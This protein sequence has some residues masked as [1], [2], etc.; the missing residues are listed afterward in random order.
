MQHLLYKV[1]FSSCYRCLV[2]LGF[3]LPACSLVYCSWIG[4][5]VPRCGKNRTA[6]SITL[7][8]EHTYIKSLS[9]HCSRKWAARILS[10]QTCKLLLEWK[11][12][13]LLLSSLCLKKKRHIQSFECSYG[14]FS[15]AANGTCTV[16]TGTVPYSMETGSSTG[17]GMG[18]LR[19]EQPQ[20]L[21]RD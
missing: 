16:H 14:N 5:Y 8:E 10:I 21:P 20:D 13:S 19:L 2:V 11:D 6:C 3:I 12:S 1:K 17:S 7:R 9:Q 15:P 4:T 18:I